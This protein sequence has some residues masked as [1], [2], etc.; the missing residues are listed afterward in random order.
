MAKRDT[1]DEENLMWILYNV[2]TVI[3]PSFIVNTGDLVDAT[4]GGPFTPPWHGLDVQQKNE[5]VGY[6]YLTRN[7]SPDKYYDLPGN[8][9]RYGDSTWNDSTLAGIYDSSDRKS[10]RLNSSHIPLSRMPSSA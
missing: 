4:N 1:K 6:Q 2:P 3:E 7:L 5:W 9:D 8:H 10:T